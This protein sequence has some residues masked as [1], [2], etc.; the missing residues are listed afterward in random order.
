V[1]SA[2]AERGFPP[3]EVVSA[4]AERGFPPDEAVSACAE[5]GLHPDETVSA[6]VYSLTKKFLPKFLSTKSDIS[7]LFLPV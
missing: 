2:R 1:V 4:R 7:V 3:D 6:R 5:R